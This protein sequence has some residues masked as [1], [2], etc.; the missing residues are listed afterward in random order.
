MMPTA[1]RDLDEARRIV[2]RHLAGRQAQVYLFG[3][4]ARGEARRF[5]DIDIAIL[6]GQPL[7]PGFLLDL[8]D[9]LETSEALYP[10]DLGRPH[11]GAGRAAREGAGG[12]SSLE[13]LKERLGLA[14][15][16][17][18]TLVDALGEPKTPLSR[19]ASI[20]RFEYTFETA[21]KAAQ[22]YLAT[23]ENLQPGSPASA[24]RGCHQ[25]AVLTEE[26]ARAALRMAKDR[27]PTVHTY[28]EALAEEIYGRLPG[29]AELIEEWLRAIHD[30]I[31]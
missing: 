19:D 27:N 12:G 13:R 7:P 20:Q 8:Q 25:T 22:A 4:R 16:A 29:H 26:Q 11:R 14:R 6:P 31:G 9:A 24:I 30:R 10:V 21:W 28:N 23:V 2:F 5:S 15:K 18:A 1:A 17:L 3:S